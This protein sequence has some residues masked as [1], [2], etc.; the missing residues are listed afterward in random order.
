VD[1]S[2]LKA[3]VVLH[4]TRWQVFRGCVV[5]LGKQVLGHLA[6]GVHQHVQAA[7]VGHADHDFLHALGAGLLDQLVH[8]GDEALT[9]LQR[10]ALLAHVFGVQI[11]LQA[12]GGRQAIQ[13][14]ALLFGAKV[15]LGTDAFQL[16]L[17]PA[18]LRLVGGVH[19]L[20]A[21]GAAVGFAQRVQQLAQGHLVLAEERVAGVEHG[22]LVG[23][24]EAVERRLQFRNVGALSALEGVQISPALAHV[25][26]GGNQL[27]NGGALAAHFGVSACNHHF[28]AASLGAF[29][30]RVDHGKVR[31]VLGIGAIHSG[32][33][34][35]CIKVFAPCVGHAARIGKVVFIHLFDIRRIAAEEVGVA[36]V[37]LIDGCRIAHIP[38]T[39]APLQGSISWLRNLPRHG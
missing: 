26:V 28:G 16:L 13:N 30:E 3:L 4:V 2:E 34:L 5:K 31:N 25:A 32:Y 19:V 7:A 23:V 29:C 15:G 38:L 14:V 12:F 36:L 35:Q 6:Q 39:S 22:F 11:A 21:Q 20:G 37:G 18:L 9:T 17:P 27:L 33:V 24:A 8:G 1:T 10:E